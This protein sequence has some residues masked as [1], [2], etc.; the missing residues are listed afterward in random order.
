MLTLI[1]VMSL[2]PLGIII[3]SAV[4]KHN[5]D[6]HNA[7]LAAERLCNEVGNQQNVLLSGAEQ[8]LSSFAYIPCIQNRDAGSASALLAKLAKKYPE[9]TNLLIADSTGHVW[10]SALP[11]RGKVM[12][13][14]RR[15]FRN[16][17]ATGSFSSGEYTLGRVLNKPALSFGY[18]IRDISGNIRDIA[19]VAFTLDSYSNLLKMKEMPSNV[20]L[21]LT[22]HKGTIL[23]D[24]GAPRFIG[25]EDKPDIFW[26]LSEGPDKG[27]FE[28]IGITGKHR[29][30]TYQTLRLGN[31]QAPYMYVR[32]GIL[33]SSLFSDDLVINVFIMFFVTLLA[34]CFALYT[35]KLGIIDKI[36]ALR[37]AAQQVG[38]GNLLVHVS[39]SV[40]G[41]E[42]GELACKFDEMSQRLA[43]DLSRRQQI[44]DSLRESETMYRMLVETANEGVWAVDTE[45]CTTFVNAQMA[46]I[47]GYSTVEML[48]RK[49]DSFIPP[50]E[51]GNYQEQLTLRHQGKSSRFERRFLKKDGSR[52]C[53]LVSA[54][55]L[56][57]SQGAYCGF[58]AMINDIT[59]K[60]QAEQHIAEAMNYIQTLLRTS[61]VGIVT[62]KSTGE[63]VSANESAARIIGA[64]IEILLKQNFREIESWKSF[65]LQKI[66]EQ[67]LT[68]GIE[69]RSDLTLV[70][71]CGN[72]IEVDTL[73][74]PFV[75]GGEQHLMLAAIDITER[76]LAETELVESRLLLEKTFASLNEAIFIVET[77]TRT[78]LDCNITC[79]RMFGYSR[80][81]MIGANTE[82]LH[83]SE[84]MSRRFGC[85]MLE[86]Y[87]D[88]GYYETVYIMKRSDGAFFDSEHSVTPIRNENGET[89]KHV[90][91]VRDISERIQLQNR[92]ESRKRF[93][94]SVLT[95]LK[96][97]IIVVDHEYRVA[98]LNQYVAEFSGEQPEVFVG[99]DLS[100]ISSELKDALLSGL[101]TGEI[102]VTLFNKAHTIGFSK[103]D[104]SSSYM[105]PEGYIINFR[106][107]TEV[108][109]IRKELRHKERLSAM[110]EVV[111]SVAHEMRNPLFAMTT[112]AQILE[113]EL[114]L[115]PAQKELI[116]SLLKESK[117]LNNLVGELLDSTR[118]LRLQRRIIDL[119]S[120]IAET[121][122]IL[123]SITDSKRVILRKQAFAERIPIFADFEKIEQVM[124]NIIKNAMEA[125]PENSFV[126]LNIEESDGYVVISVSDC[127][128]GI[129]PEAMEKIFEV[130]YTT[131]KHGTGLGLSICK[132]IVDAHGGILD[133]RNN[134]DAGATI[135]VK[136]PAGGDA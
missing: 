107:L 8:L 31:E 90:C 50:E 83:V 98:M 22:D 95:Y 46:D 100:E 104:L 56:Y 41:G 131:K 62:F 25:K 23:F 67:A 99:K 10:A 43:A 129:P 84:E 79:E 18:P 70:N 21:V 110:G 60:K 135:T 15:F 24:A 5:F 4:Q 114:T 134:P 86:A 36:L 71:S 69:Q 78:I 126:D 68:T 105:E 76:K 112:V 128:A 124:L 38:N 120:V 13:D 109:K 37:D 66:A 12:A 113:M 125:S 87:A 58:F 52:I 133:V 32:A 101:S 136:L 97:G 117:R 28:A 81:E 72:R 91:V 44:L 96:S 106:D 30:F 89:V 132:N 20:S 65:G 48:G 3:F 75:F 57:N 55:T 82:F 33:K 77:G 88:K 93:V 11:M 74:V 34:I 59:D 130:F 80:S 119:N 19:I 26:R 64:P 2:A 63:A 39:G 9:I 14:D 54:A 121:F 73:F 27:N 92:L 17:L 127:G 45:E 16:A 47:L 1:F 111:A 116:D 61:P 123:Q 53:A 85:E 108:I 29:Y 49:I 118:E 102:T 51:T 40:S 94:E 103:F 115:T 7:Y 35:S 122:R 6:E 42:L